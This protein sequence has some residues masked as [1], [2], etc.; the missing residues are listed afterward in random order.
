ML[1]QL[2]SYFLLGI[3]LA[4]PI[5]PINAAQLD[6]GIK[7][8][9]LHAWLVGIG[10]ILVDGIYMLIVYFGLVHFIDIEPIKVFLWLFGFFVLVYTG[11]ES[12]IYSNKV[13]K[14]TRG[15]DA[16]KFKSFLY[17]FML[18]IVNPLT[19]LFWVGIYGSV[20]AE[21]ASSLG[22]RELI[23]CSLAIFMGLLLW[24][25]TMAAISSSF[26]KIM[27]HQ[28]LAFISIASGLALICFGIYFGYRGIMLLFG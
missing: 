5:G 19:I 28:F 12:I 15:N 13:F 27:T 18:S 21:T 6:K 9:F 26:R 3:S 22:N 8:G 1:S 20:L 24:D 4:A 11:V 16:S 7:Y 25:I 10:A 23:L 2:F 17:G 14:N